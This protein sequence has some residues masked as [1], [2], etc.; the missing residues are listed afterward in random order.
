MNAHRVTLSLL[1]TPAVVAAMAISVPALAG[2]GSSPAAHQARAHTCTA[3]IVISHHRRIRACLLRGPRGF[4]GFP[5]SRGATGS[6]G[7]T[8]ATGRT[9]ATGATGATGPQ[10]PAGTARAYAVVQPT[11]PSAAS[12]I[13]PVN[14]TGVTEPAP[15]VYCVT[16]AAG[17]SPSSYPPVASQEISYSSAGVGV[18][19]VNVQH[20]NCPT[21]F[22]VDTYATTSAVKTGTATGFAF[23]IVIP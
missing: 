23:V 16:P 15:G 5:G 19:T 20:P 9:G 12:L 18:I 6:R 22:E 14:I 7:K 4:T 13:A 21:G 17:I 8:G 10:G 11:S 2:T 1:A 3:V